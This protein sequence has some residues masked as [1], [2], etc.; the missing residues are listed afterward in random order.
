[1]SAKNKGGG[2]A[3][4]QVAQRVNPVPTQSGPRADRFAREFLNDVTPKPATIPL[5]NPD[6]RPYLMIEKSLGTGNL[7]KVHSAKVEVQE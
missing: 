5:R 6:T 3:T 2:S 7:N 4:R 1:M